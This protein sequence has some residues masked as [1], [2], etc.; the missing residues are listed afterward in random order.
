MDFQKW[1]YDGIS[2]SSEGEE[3]RLIK[4]FLEENSESDK[5][6]E[7]SSEKDREWYFSTFKRFKLWMEDTKSFT[8]F[9]IDAQNI[10]QR[11]YF[12]QEAKK[13]DPFLN[14][15]SKNAGSYKR[16]YVAQKQTETEHL[17]NIRKQEKLKRLQLQRKVGFR[18]LFK[19]LVASKKPLIGHNLLYDLLFMLN[20]FQGPLPNSWADAKNLVHSLFPEIYDTKLLALHFENRFTSTSLETLYNSLNKE[21]QNGLM[22]SISISLPLGFLDYH[23]DI[24]NSSGAHEAGYDAY[25]TG[26]VFLRLREDLNGDVKDFVNRVHL[27]HSFYVANLDGNDID[28]TKGPVVLVYDFDKRMT[29]TDFLQL[30]GDRPGQISWINDTSCYLVMANGVDEDELM[31]HLKSVPNIKASLRQ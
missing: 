17:C 8:E 23:P 12:Q 2:Y 10:L 4:E 28:V 24:I 31:N 27:M 19:L 7:L 3:S 1:I 6:L 5:N 29:T 11:L 9:D 26:C 30:L 18:N 20:S 25:I 21:D 22:K 14:F 15:Y 13:E 16:R